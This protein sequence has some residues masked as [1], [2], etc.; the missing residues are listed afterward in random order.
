MNVLTSD[1]VTGRPL[2]G[3]KLETAMNR[4]LWMLTGNN[5]RLSSEFVRRC[6]RVRMDTGLERPQARG[7]SSFRHADLFGWTLAN[8][9]RLIRAL[10]VIVLYWR[11]RGAPRG[12]RSKSSFNSWAAIVGGIMEEVALPGFLGNEDAFFEEVDVEADEWG[13]FVRAWAEARAPGQAFTASELFRIAD[14]KDLLVEVRTAQNERA[15]VVRFGKALAAH[16]DQ[17]FGEL[18]IV[19]GGLSS[20]T[21][22]WKLERTS[23]DADA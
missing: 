1:S 19:R 20:G 3:S 11:S 7:P 13:T 23:A 15:N 2:G 9:S 22:L 14:S 10:I 5:P 18:K 4:A 16:R 6:V 12:T 17:V 21:R 8:R